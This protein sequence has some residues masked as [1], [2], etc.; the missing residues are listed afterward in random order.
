MQTHGGWARTIEAG[1]LRIDVGLIAAQCANSRGNVN[2]VDGRVACGPL[3]HTM[4][5]VQFADRVAA[6]VDHLAAFPICPIEMRQDQV[7]FVV[8]VELM[9]GPRGILSGTTRPTHDPVGLQIAA[10]AAQV[11]SPASCARC[12]SRGCPAPIFGVRCF[13]LAAV[14]SYRRDPR[15]KQLWAWR[16]WKRSPPVR[17]DSRR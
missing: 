17:G 2:R 12:S 15:T 8:T 13:D 9:G 6:I 5:E 16:T 3:G 11:A 4:V 14:D 1:K 10:T 7:D